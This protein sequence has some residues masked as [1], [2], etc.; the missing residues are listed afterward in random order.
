M[1]I[2]TTREKQNNHNL[3]FQKHLIQHY[4]IDVMG[5]DSYMEFERMRCYS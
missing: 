3:K 2:A 4:E 5:M 1:N